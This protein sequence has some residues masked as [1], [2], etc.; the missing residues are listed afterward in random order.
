MTLLSNN[1]E[2]NMYDLLVLESFFSLNAVRALECVMQSLL[3]YAAWNN[4]AWE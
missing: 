2:Q 1:G 3:G 4:L